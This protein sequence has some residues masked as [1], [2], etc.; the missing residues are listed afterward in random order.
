[1]FYWKVNGHHPHEWLPSDLSTSSL[2]QFKKIFFELSW[3]FFLATCEFST[4]LEYDKIFL[5]SSLRSILKNY[6]THY[7]PWRP[8]KKSS[9]WYPENKGRKHHKC[10]FCFKQK[11]F[12][13]TSYSI[14]IIAY[15]A[16]LHTWFSLMILALLV[17]SALKVFV[18]IYPYL[19]LLPIYWE[20][21]CHVLVIWLIANLATEVKWGLNEV[22]SYFTSNHDCSM[23]VLPKKKKKKLYQKCFTKSNWFMKTKSPMSMKKKI[24]E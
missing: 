21:I 22:Y 18:I 17:M 9:I 12:I 15:N 8:E 14:Y 19:F 13:N 5:L 7:W 2:P 11:G 4:Y 1:M 23:W 3:F 24:L 6:P 16:L 20:S 10:M